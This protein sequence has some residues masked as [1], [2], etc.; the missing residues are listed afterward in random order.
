MTRLKSALATGALVAAMTVG[1][2]AATTSAASADVACN[3]WGE[4]WH[5]RDHYT[6]YPANLGVIFHD[7][8]W[9]LAHQRGNWR[10][11]HDRNDDH[12][13]YSHGHWRRF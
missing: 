3:R 11:R 1:A 7:E 13:Y 10:W 12:G 5:V 2:L 6:N 8:A 4:C 9:R